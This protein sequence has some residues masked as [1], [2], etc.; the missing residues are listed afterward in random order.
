MLLV[1]LVSHA[2]HLLAQDGRVVPGKAQVGIGGVTPQGLQEGPQTVV[3]VEKDVAFG[4]LDQG[5][6]VHAAFHLVNLRE[7]AGT[8][9]T[10]PDIGQSGQSGLSVFAELEDHPVFSLAAVQ[11]KH[12]LDHSVGG[13]PDEI[14]AAVEVAFPTT[15]AEVAV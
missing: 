8:V 1:P 10:P 2:A 6:D 4:A 9:T 15:T 14:V 12:L 5:Q 3:V 13:E 11:R 7:R